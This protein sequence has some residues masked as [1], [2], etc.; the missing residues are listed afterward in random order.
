[1]QPGLQ[2][3]WAGLK[4]DTGV[5]SIG[6]QKGQNA[7]MGVVQVEQDVTG[8][9]VPGIGQDVNITAFA[10][11]DAQEANGSRREQLGGGPESFS[12][13]GT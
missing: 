12:G 8:I 11:A 7:V 10:V 1:M 4:N 6:P 9:V 5:M 2:V 13:N 3:T